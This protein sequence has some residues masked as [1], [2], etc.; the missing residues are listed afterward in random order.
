M[1]IASSSVAESRGIPVV[2]IRNTYC[3]C[4]IRARI[5]I[6]ESERNSNRLY[7]TCA[8]YPKCN[9]YVRLTPRRVGDREPGFCD[10]RSVGFAIEGDP[11]LEAEMMNRLQHVLPPFPFEQLLPL[12]F[13]QVSFSVPWELTSIG[14]GDSTSSV[15]GL[16][17][18]FSRIHEI[19]DAY[20][21]DRL[22]VLEH[23]VIFSMMKYG[24]L[25]FSSK[26]IQYIKNCFAALAYA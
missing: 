6:S 11:Q 5:M 14:D 2:G 21:S 3:E 24:R 12:P 26:Q 18:F 22:V 8:K 19:S 23:L 16:M 4:S 1:S 25:N 7:A 15:R 10:V 20:E 9:Y 17:P 13:V